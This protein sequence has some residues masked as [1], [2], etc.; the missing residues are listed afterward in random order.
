MNDRLTTSAR[1]ASVHWPRARAATAVRLF[2][3]GVLLTLASVWAVAAPAP[4]AAEP[5]TTAAPAPAPGDELISARQYAADLAAL[6]KNPHRLAG[7]EDGSRAASAYVETRL[8]EMGFDDAELFLQEF[9]VV[10]AVPSDVSLQSGEKTYGPGDGFHVFRPNLLTP[11]VTPADGITG[12]AIYVGNGAMP[13]YGNR[14]P[15]NRIVVMDLDCQ[16]NWLNAF[17]LGAR[18]VIFIGSTKPADMCLQYLNLPANL[19]RFYVTPELAEKLQLRTKPQTLALKANNTWKQLQGRN[20]V[21]VVRGT[22][23]ERSRLPMVL[24]AALD[25][26]GIVPDLSPGARDAANVACLLQM[27]GAF[28]AERPARTTVFCFLDGQSQ[29]QM[30]ARAFYAATMLKASKGYVPFDEQRT[31]ATDER[32]FAETVL[33][34]FADIRKTWKFDL[35]VSDLDEQITK[36]QAENPNAAEPVAALEQEKKLRND[37]FD[38]AIRK[39]KIEAKLRDGR[40]LDDLAPIRNRLIE[41]EKEKAEARGAAKEGRISGDQLDARMAMLDIER[42]RLRPRKD[43]LAVEDRA[44]NSLERVIHRKINLHDEAQVSD[45][46]A[47]VDT[48]PFYIRNPEDPTKTIESDKFYYTNAE[49]KVATE[50]KKARLMRLAPEYFTLLLDSAEKQVRDRVAEL[51]TLLAEI[52]QAAAV[53]AALGT[54]GE[55]GRVSLNLS[56]NLGDAVDR[57]SFLH[58]D[59]TEVIKED[60]VGDYGPVLKPLESI[61]TSLQAAGKADNFSEQGISQIFSDVRIFS[62]GRFVESGSVARLFGVHNLTAMTVFDRLPRQGQPADTLQNLRADVVLNQARTFLRFVKEMAGNRPALDLKIRKSYALFNQP[63]WKGTTA[64]GGAVKRAGGGSAMADFPVPHAIVALLPSTGYDGIRPEGKPTDYQPAI[65]MY[66]NANGIFTPPAIHLDSYKQPL[67]LAMSYDA[68]GHGLPTYCSTKVTL[69]G[70]SKLDTRSLVLFPCDVKTVVGYGYDRGAVA[71]K[72]MRAKTT[73]PFRDDEHLD[74]ELGNVLSLFAPRHTKGYKLFCDMGAVLLG[75]EPTEKLYTGQGLSLAD[76]FEHPVTPLVSAMDLMNLNNY[77]LLL[78]REKRINQDSL[79]RLMGKAQDLGDDAQTLLSGVSTKKAAE[80]DQAGRTITPDRVEL[81]AALAEGTTDKYFGN[82]A[83][84][85][86]YG[87]AAYKPTVAV[88][89]DLVTAVV[90]L[91]LLSMPFAFALERLLVGTPHI[92]RQIGWFAVFFVVTFA[93]LF[94]V[95]PAFKIAATPIIIFL[96]FAIILLSSLVIF[97]MVRKLQTEIRKMQGLATTVHSADVSRLSTVMAAVNMGISTMRRRP[98]RTLL[99]STTVVLLTFTILT[100]ASF[101]SQYGNRRTS[102]GPLTGN[103]PRILLRHQLWSPLGEGVLD[104]LRGNMTGE[105]DVVPRYWVSPTASQVVA[106]V[107]EGK[108]F[109]MA[110]TLPD[111]REIVSQEAAIGLDLRD[112]RTKDKDGKVTWRQKEL[113]DLLQ[114]DLDLLEQDGVFLNQVAAD[115]LGLGEEDIGKA[116]VLLAGKPLTFAG[117]VADRL[118]SFTLM[119][120]SSV[121]PVD[122]QA[123]GGDE[124][125]AFGTGALP[126]VPQP[127]TGSASFIYYNVDRVVVLGAKTAQDLGGKLR[128]ITIYPDDVSKMDALSERASSISQLPTY[129]G[130]R[131]GVD[132]LIFTSLAQASGWKDLLVPVLL[133]GLIIFATLLGSVSDRAKE[134]YTFSSLGLAP[135]HVAS[136]FF[137]EAAVYAVIGGMGGYLLGQVMAVLLGWMNS[138]G[139]IS[140]PTMNYSSTNAIVTILIVMSTVLI[141]TIYPAVKASRSANP[142]I[143]RAWRIPKPDGN[144]YDLVFPFTVSAYDITGVVSFLREHFENYTD[145]SIGCFATTRCGVFRQE[146]NDMLGF[147]AS[148]ALAP[149]DLGVNQDFAMLSQRS[150]IEGIDEVR[151]LIYRTSGTPGDWRRA[152]RLFINDLRKQLLIWRS[153]PMEVMERYRQQTLESWAHLPRE[154]IDPRTFGSMAVEDQA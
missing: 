59:D 28:H 78:L 143:Q 9:P 47:D 129:Q 112:I 38:R 103:T 36:I 27:A 89:N 62:P 80:V 5:P 14:I 101:G 16:T 121:I 98:L 92:Y 149:F 127:D 114:G 108:S 137:A 150:D 84:A 136:L 40:I 26:Y 74:C 144:L 20:V 102:E 63:T 71:T 95:N 111:C 151:I 131:G 152:N 22:V 91:L 24:T 2:S 35:D 48:R 145:T 107:A 54:D 37:Y 43:E 86:A 105:A 52:D 69:T 29:A 53:A 93:V 46:F 34:I 154:T 39:L 25:T 96:A 77:R 83:A 42:D 6:T 116:K 85:H 126:G 4:S 7:F 45:L 11:N 135:P 66:S 73:S 82:L 75:N 10:Q 113:A 58:G 140:V 18:A 99:T 147:R 104:V 41:I 13:Q 128:A 123:S 117:I 19:P 97:I 133:G 55:T 125:G 51:D 1:S 17:A 130:H 132:R 81:P 134:I 141:S 32:H 94:L 142:G 50:T 56:L 118:N 138:M 122:Y 148:V 33:D 64:V 68:R 15:Q 146:G 65:L 49:G 8:R 79:E 106:A 153:L 70:D 44:W 76:P 110:L 88:M 60:R 31:Q 90:L 30:G 57:W 23:P 87:R 12:E 61:Y 100:F 119:E 72:V 124:K 120:G 67:L 3:A 21:A 139:W 115:V 109:S